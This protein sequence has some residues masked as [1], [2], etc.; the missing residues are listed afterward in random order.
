MAG[1]VSL[2][3]AEP[4]ARYDF[5][6]SHPLRPERLDLTA[7]LIEVCGL[8]RLPGVTVVRPRLATDQELAMVHDPSYVALVRRL[9][10][11]EADE[12][13]GRRSGF[14]PGD[15]PSFRRAH[16]ASAWVAGASIVGIAEILEGKS[17]HAFNPGGG[18]HHAMAGRASGFCVYNDPAVAIAWALR[19]CPKWRVLYVDVDAHH[20]DGVQAAFYDEARVLTLSIHESGRYLFPGTGFPRELGSPAALGTSV[21]LP[22]PPGTADADYLF[23]F[24]SL[25]PAVAAS[26]SPDLLVT[27]L[28]CDSHWGDPLTHLGLTMSAYPAIYARCHELAHELCEGRWLATGGGGYQWATVVPRAWTLAFAE[29]AAPSPGG[30]LEL[31]PDRIPPAWAGSRL[32][33]APTRFLADASPDTSTQVRSTVESSL[34]ELRGL[35]APLA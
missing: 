24:D 12:E 27:Q 28:G 6:P 10:R 8:D 32:P 3:W 16:E 26:F 11:G 5:G 17:S 20:G 15:N 23:A 33:G 31:L 14:G 29:M 2:V 34:L 22:L 1:P 9:G 7:S 35:L 18:L 4:P 30:A 21:N 13:E 25:V 19:R